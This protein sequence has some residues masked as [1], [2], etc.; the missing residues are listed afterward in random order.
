MGDNVFWSVN[1]KWTVNVPYNNQWQLFVNKDTFVVFTSDYSAEQECHKIDEA[2]DMCEDK[3]YIGG[4]LLN[5][6]GIKTAQ[7]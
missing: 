2:F 7:S 5:A 1:G 6:I 3:T 4:N